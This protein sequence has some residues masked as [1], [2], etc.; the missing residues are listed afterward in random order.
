MYE[1]VRS[2]TVHYPA[3]IQ[4]M[5][6]IRK[7]SPEAVLWSGGTAIMGYLR[8]Y[9]ANDGKDI[10]YLGN[11]Q[12]LKRI[13]RSERYLEI[14]SQVSIERMLTVGQHIL[15][16][17]LAQACRAIGPSIV[18]SQVTIGGSLCLPERYMN[19]AC[20][21]SVLEVL[22]EL[23]ETEGKQAA[24]WVPLSRLYARSSHGQLLSHAIVTRIRVMFEPAD[25][26]FFSAIGRPFFDPSDAIIFSLFVKH[27]QIA[28]S[29]FRFAFAFPAIGI[30]R[31]RELESS[32]TS[33]DI[34]IGTRDIT[35]ISRQLR[36]DILE[37]GMTPSPL[38]LERAART[39]ELALHRLNTEALSATSRY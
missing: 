27:S 8:P 23:R 37:S 35:R 20:A 38:Q 16:P 14:G 22:V 34:P 11:V 18:R 15:H 28:I 24:R 19:L 39:F 29:E 12:E 25:F 3:T 21:L 10:I 6:S 13:S 4:E 5:L 33:F 32:M 2:P 9:P 1:G 36:A 31:N 17:V 30:Y 7:R 26:Q